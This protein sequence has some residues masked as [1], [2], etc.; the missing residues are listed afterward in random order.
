LKSDKGETLEAEEICEFMD[1]HGLDTLHASNVEAMILRFDTTVFEAL[2][3]ADFCRMWRE[4]KE[5]HQHFALLLENESA[6]AAEKE[7]LRLEGM[8]IRQLQIREKEKMMR[9]VAA[10][11]TIQRI[12][13]GRQARKFR[14][15]LDETKRSGEVNIKIKS[16][17]R[18]RPNP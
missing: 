3:F 5:L 16:L 15:W 6:E 17:S 12:V 7:E 1:K 10:V 13:R 18:L 2:G 14:I 9:E 4:D 8:V 11:K